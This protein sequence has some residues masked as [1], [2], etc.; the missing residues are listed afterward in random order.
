MFEH[1]KK[2][3]IYEHGK[4]TINSDELSQL[5]QSGWEVSK[6][7]AMGRYTNEVSVYKRPIRIEVKL[8]RTLNGKE[9]SIT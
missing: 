5:L 9:K 2:A 7:Y 6:K 3:R 8:R 1:I 4:L